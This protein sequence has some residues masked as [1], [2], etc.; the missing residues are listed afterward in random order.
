MPYPNEHSCTIRN[1]KDFEKKSFK[2]IV[3]K[4]LAII[5]AR[6]KGKKTTTTQAYRYPIKDWTK[7]EAQEHCKEHKGEF[8]PA[9]KEVQHFTEQGILEFFRKEGR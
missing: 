9:K 3:K 6:L 8:H 5:I 1:S 4:K 2:R 7:K